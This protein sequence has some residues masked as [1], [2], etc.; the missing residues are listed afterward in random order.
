MT[1]LT[2]VKAVLA[3][4]KRLAKWKSNPGLR[5]KLP[6][7][8]LTP[9][10]RLARRMGQEIFPGA[11]ITGFEQARQAKSATDQVY[12][13]QKL[14]LQHQ[15]NTVAAQRQRNA[16][17]WDQYVGQLRAMQ[18]PAANTQTGPDVGA[19]FGAPAGTGT[20]QVQASAGGYQPALSSLAAG[21][22]A[23]N[24]A[25]GGQRKL[26]SLAGL[27][28]VELGVKQKQGALQKEADLFK[29]DQK[30]KITA[31]SRQQYL[32][33]LA[34]LG[35]NAT[36][37]LAAKRLAETTRHN[38]AGENK[39]PAPK[40]GPD[41]IHTVEEFRNAT[42]EQKAAW[43]K[44]VG[45]GPKSPKAKSPK[46]GEP[47]S[48]QRK[49]AWDTAMAALGGKKT[50][51]LD[52]KGRVVYLLNG[53]AVYP[54][55]DGKVPSGATK[56][57]RSINPAYARSHREGLVRGLILEK[58]IP[59]VIAVRAVDRFINGSSPTLGSGRS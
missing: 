37:E 7:K 52:G 41:G 14:A 39:P 19:Q 36:Q 13:P 24:V 51:W 20:Q 15:A 56:R 33:N 35:K 40:Y 3:D 18:A 57:V 31:A 10:Q 58:K 34:Y 5:G 26:E 17:W 48:P 49:A 44:E 42:P 30:T 23:N 59:R 21:L 53:K 6:E 16:G 25:S 2:G 29:Q 11:G 43:L 22:L 8:Y 47:G 32:E 4:P 50:P 9:E 1:K 54:D 28:A 45:K 55:K 27:D 12:G 38:K 46:A